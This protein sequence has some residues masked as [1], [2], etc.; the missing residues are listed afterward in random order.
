[1]TEPRR[2]NGLWLTVAVGHGFFAIFFVLVAILRINGDESAWSVAGAFGMIV[3]FCAF[4][5]GSVV[6]YRNPPVPADHKRH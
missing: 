6:R 5:A 3:L 4:A 2:G 1:M